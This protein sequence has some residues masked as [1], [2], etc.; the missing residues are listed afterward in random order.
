MDN[1]N[2]GFE[3][4]EDEL[5]EQLSQMLKQQNAANQMIEKLKSERDTA[6]KILEDATHQN[7]YYCSEKD[8]SRNCQSGKENVKRSYK[9]KQIYA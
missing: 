1:T 4:T 9:I 7:A 6:I 8:C 2:I 3:S 5:Q